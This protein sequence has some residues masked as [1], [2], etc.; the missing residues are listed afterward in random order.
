MKPLNLLLIL[1][2]FSL[3]AQQTE[4]FKNLVK[5][6]EKLSVKTDTTFYGNGQIEYIS[7]KTTYTFD[8]GIYDTWTGRDILY[9]RNGVTARVSIKDDYGNFL[10]EKFYDRDGNLTKEWITSEIDN[11]AKSLKNYLYNR[12]SDGYTL[13]NIK[14]KLNYYKYSKRLKKRFIYKQEYIEIS[15][16]IL[17]ESRSFMDENGIITKTKV[18]TKRKKNVW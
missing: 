13:G 5:G 11:R 1:I 8:D 16:G 14:K 4:R 3:Q 2:C 10:N 9:Y 15:N 12:S 18:T 17:T 7:E 6:L